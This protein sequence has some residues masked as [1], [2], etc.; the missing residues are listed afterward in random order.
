VLAFS[1]DE[2]LHDELTEAGLLARM[3]A[4]ANV[5]VISLPGRDHTLRPLAAQRAAHG[6]LA[7]AIGREAER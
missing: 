5:E 2:P 6:V 1:G 4:L 7:R 3:G